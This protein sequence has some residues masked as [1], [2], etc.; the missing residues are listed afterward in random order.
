MMQSQ[1]REDQ[2]ED[3]RTLQFSGESLLHII[4]DILDFTKLDSGKIELSA[5]DFNLRELAQSLY[6]S[7]GFTAREKNIVFDVEYD[8]KMPFYV[9]GD[10]FRLSQVLNNLISNAIKFTQ[11]GFVKLKVELLENKEGAYVTQFSVIDS[12][13]GI[14]EEKQEKIFEQ[15]TQ[16]DSDTTRL[17]GGTGLGLSISSRLVELMG[18][19]IVVTSTPGK[20]SSFQFNVLLQPGSMT[21]ENGVAPAKVVTKSNEQFKNKLILL[22]EDNVFNANIA[23]RFITG[24]GAQLEI[25]VDGRQALEFVSRRKYDLILMDVQMPVLDGFACTRKIRKHFKD[26]PIIAITA[27]PRN[28]I[29]HEIMACG[30]NDFV[31][32]PF[33][34]NELRNKLLEWL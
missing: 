10:S 34:P 12:G 31:S 18:S 20:G 17:Y 5:I 6:Q 19:A 14:A 1:P 24:W 23:R 2:Q 11:E 15:F 29:I 16:A 32:K 13:I 21:S 22:A 7:F 33:K 3:L 25:V 26:V 27:S 30:M 28:E 8:Q 4:N 9:K